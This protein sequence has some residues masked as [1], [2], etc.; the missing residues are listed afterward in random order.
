MLL[1]PWQLRTKGCHWQVGTG[2]RM[3]NYDSVDKGLFD[4]LYKGYEANSKEPWSI[5]M[6]TV[7]YTFDTR[8]CADLTVEDAMKRNGQIKLKIED[9]EYY[10]GV[11][12]ILMHGFRPG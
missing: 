5:H 8:A 2:P 7:Q 9:L 6:D 11:S 1:V 10:P 4:Y 12:N 3:D